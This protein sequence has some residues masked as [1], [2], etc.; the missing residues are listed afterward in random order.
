MRI[1]ILTVLLALA[2]T[3]AAHEGAG[4]NVGV[5]VGIGAPTALS[6]EVAPV[7]WSAFELALGLPT[8][9]EDNMYAHLVYK[10]DFATLAASRTVVVP[11]YIGAGAFVHEH[12]WTDWGARFPLGVN[13]DFQRAPVQLFAEAALQAVLVTENGHDRPIDLAGFG[14]VRFWF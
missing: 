9:S 7:P 12:G 5:G 1:R 3:A 6:I 13:F 10:L 14:G 2:G 8:I 11:L 4:G